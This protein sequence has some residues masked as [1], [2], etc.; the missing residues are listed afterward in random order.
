MDYSPSYIYTWPKLLKSYMGKAHVH[1]LEVGSLEGISACWMLQNVLNHSSSRLTCIDTFRCDD[2]GQA[3][4]D[5]QSDGDNDDFLYHRFIHNITLA[6][7]LSRVTIV[8]QRAESA[9]R[10]LPFDTYDFIHL[11]ASRTAKDVLSDAVLAWPLLKK[12]GL[13]VFDDYGWNNPCD[14]TPRGAPRLAIDT[15]LSVFSGDYEVFL[16]GY[17]VI[18]RKI[19]ESK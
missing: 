2:T 13:L 8:R 3:I 17:Q 9:L 16:Q 7:G 11:D 14:P 5:L 6:D 15:F 18:I 1:F 4:L 19:K 12:L 10:V